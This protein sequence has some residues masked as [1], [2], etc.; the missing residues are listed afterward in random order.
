MT[1]GSLSDHARET[2]AARFVGRAGELAVVDALLAPDA[3][4][5][6]LLISGPGGIGKSA[7]LREI[8]RRADSGGVPA[9]VH[10][11]RE[12]PVAVDQL[13]VALRPDPDLD[14]PMVLI[15]EADALGANLLTVRDSLLEL[16][17][18]ARVVIAGR[19]DPDPSWHTGALTPIVREL[20]LRPLGDADAEEL[21]RT[22]GVTDADRRR[23]ILEWAQGSPL[24]LVVASAARGEAA[25]G[26]PEAEL[27]ERLAN[28]LGGAEL[29]GVDRA[30]LEVAALTRA[31][32]ARLLAA[33]L[34]GHPTRSAMPSLLRLSVVERHDGRAILHPVLARAIGERMRA[35][36]PERYRVTLRRIAD[37]LATRAR[38]GDPIALFELTD[39]LEDPAIRSGAGLGASATHYA[40]AL[41]EGDIERVVHDAHV[42]RSSL[43][44]LL[45][46][47]VAALPEFAT[48]IRA[49][50]G[51]L[52][53]LGL[54]APFER[55]AAAPVDDPEVSALLAELV[56]QGVEPAHTLVALAVVFLGSDP[57]TIAETL[58]VG[59]T[60]IMARTGFAGVRWIVARY[61][62]PPPMGEAFL[63]SMGYRRLHLPDSARV[64]GRSET[65]L[66]DFGPDGLVGYIHA[67]VLGEHGYSATGAV[68]VT[69]MLRDAAADA[70]AREDLSQAIAGA[71]GDSAEERRLARVLELT[72]LAAMGERAILETLHVSRAT[73]YRLLRAARERLAMRLARD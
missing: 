26:P 67:T 3:V 49:V 35:T 7:L 32:D 66:S 48:T 23:P 52:T 45:P 72:H 25:T 46:A 31:V 1:P 34:P 29:D 30:V 68:D 14:N 60:G 58:R 20:T 22:Y 61:P 39:L 40:D 19:R 55:V 50:G 53:G 56:A 38:V 12:L 5:R 42:G 28:L 11:A 59:N 21:L 51:E 17:R 9:V 71:F 6:I 54:F 41:R 65:W 62:G 57:V 43:A 69:G 24:A 27:E 13:A 8:A 44:P 63:E 4:A 73:Y 70:G 2:E 64:E 36:E 18:D 37:H 10:D 16:P 15:D 47:W 33:A